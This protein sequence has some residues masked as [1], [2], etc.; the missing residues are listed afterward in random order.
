MKT[1][2][3]PALAAAVCLTLSLCATGALAA[4]DS[5][6]SETIRALGIM[7]G[8]ETGDL[9]L[10]ANVTRAEFV[11]MMTAASSYKDTVGSG[12]GVSLFQDVKS[13]Y[14]GSQYVKLAVEQGWMC[15]YVDGTFRPDRTITLEES[16]TALLRLLGYDSSS[17]TGSFPTAQLNKAASAGLLDGMA[18]SQGHTMTRQDCVDLFY[19]LLTAQNS[20]GSA[21]GASLGYTVTNGEVD[22]AS[23]VSADT[24][25]PY[26][27]SDGSLTLPFTPTAVYRDGAAAAL[28]DV[29]TYDVYYYNTNLRAVWVYS[30]RVSG[31]LTGLSPSK[32]APTSATV[33]GV[34]YSIGTSTAAYKLSSQGEFTTGDLV[35]VL[36]GMDGDIVDVVDAQDSESVY[37]GVVVSSSKSA[38]STSSGSS[39]VQAVTQVACTDGAVRTFYHSGSALSAGKLVTVSVTQSGTT[40]KSLSAKSLEGTVNAA[41]T[42]LAGYTF[43]DNVEILDTDG[44]GGYVRIYPSRLAGAKLSGDD[45]RGYTLD[46]SGNIDRLILSEVT[47]DTYPYAYFTKA[48][49]TSGDMNISGSY[50]YLVNGESHSLNTNNVAYSVTT[51][52]AALIYKD[53]EL[54]SIRQ[55][56]SVTLD[57]LT[58]LSASAGNKK[59][60]LSED[61]QVLLRDTSGSKGYYSTSLSQINASDYTL[62]G[63]YDNLGCSAGGR[64]R[65]IVAV[66]K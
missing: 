10:S 35:T 5:A 23:L 62:K 4:G 47:G 50:Q 43:A 9:N 38:S 11:T 32:T 66:E 65:I 12:Y 40:V 30:D 25:G 45:V 34:T 31:T 48:E 22:Y 29:Q 20:T 13:S 64:I 1:H 7:V 58:S 18:L 49:N 46:A 28:S 3:I 55:L 52:G 24:K 36:L 21:Y 57:G 33:A 19:N 16:C 61:V 14:W 56:T 26:V 6:K 37:C 44:N 8:D 51:G 17:L 42:K 59:Y 41:G 39:S 60:T 2:R 53:G 63:W 15:G 54:K 27:A